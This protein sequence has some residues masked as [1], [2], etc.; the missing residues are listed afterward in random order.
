MSLTMWTFKKFFSRAFGCLKALIWAFL[1][2]E[3]FPHTRVEIRGQVKE[4][5]TGGW[6]HGRQQSERERTKDYRLN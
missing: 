1:L 5:K 4:R 3:V 6:N 2:N